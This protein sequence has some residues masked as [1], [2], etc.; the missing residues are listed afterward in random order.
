MIYKRDI[1]NVSTITN[2]E[3]SRNQERHEQIRQGQ[4]KVSNP[5]PGHRGL[6]SFDS[7]NLPRPKHHSPIF[8]FSLSS[9]SPGRVQRLT[10][11]AVLTGHRLLAR[12]RLPALAHRGL[13]LGLTVLLFI[14]VSVFCYGSFYSSVIPSQ[15][16]RAIFMF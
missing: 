4:E 11:E 7:T 15:V 14:A 5:N 9:C 6:K 2:M 16:H 1:L 12:S 3:Q 13:E 8:V 10:S